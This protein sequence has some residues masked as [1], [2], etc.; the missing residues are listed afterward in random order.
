M[1]KFA[2]HINVDVMLNGRF[3]HTF[4]IPSLLA[5]M[6]SPN[7]ALTYSVEKIQRYIEERMPSLKGRA[8]NIIFQ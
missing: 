6:I 2:N 3:I 5:D 8:Y 7:G 4:S 1:R